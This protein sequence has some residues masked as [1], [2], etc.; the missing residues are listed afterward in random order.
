MCGPGTLCPNAMAALGVTVC[1]SIDELAAASDAIMM[2]RIQR[3]RL[4]P[5]CCHRT[6]SM[7]L[8]GLV[9]RECGRRGLKVYSA[10]APMNRG[11]EI[12]DAM[13]DSDSSMVLRQVQNGLLCE[14][15]F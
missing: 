9:L 11:V 8:Y 13:A 7:R 4:G 10:S 14:W 12:D 6:P 1:R 15:P 3:E 2:L 5:R